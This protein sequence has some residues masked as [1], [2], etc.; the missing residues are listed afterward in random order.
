MPLSMLR[1]YTL[2]A[3]EI[4]LPHP[5]LRG[6]RVQTLEGASY[7]QALGAHIWYFTADYSTD[8]A[9]AVK[10]FDRNWHAFSTTAVAAPC[11]PCPVAE[12]VLIT[13]STQLAVPRIVTSQTLESAGV[14][15]F[16]LLFKISVPT[17]KA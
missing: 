12:L 14:Y 17:Y 5:T 1:C 7:L 15:L 8:L 3:G 2:L 16:D 6:Q 10:A 4:D 9:T 13:P 11:P